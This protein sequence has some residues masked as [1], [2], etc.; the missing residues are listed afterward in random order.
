ML[1]GDVELVHE[2]RVTREGLILIPQVG[3]LFVNHLTMEQF[4]KLLRRR[5]GQWYSGIGSGTTMT[6]GAYRFQGSTLTIT[7]G[8]GLG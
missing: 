7:A 4:H 8:R 1:T 3:Q 5:L 2:L 6:S